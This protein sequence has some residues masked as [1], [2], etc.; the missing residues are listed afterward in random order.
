M[1]TLAQLVACREKLIYV[2]KSGNWTT[3]GYPL[4]HGLTFFT[5]MV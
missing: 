5:N 2:I 3:K 1:A 4:Q